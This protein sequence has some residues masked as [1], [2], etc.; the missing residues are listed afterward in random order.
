MKAIS[1]QNVTKSFGPKKILNNVSFDLE[2]NM[3]YGFVG[4]NGAGKTTTIKNDF[5]IV[6]I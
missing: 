4:P 2:E 3:I 6:K 1:F 5:R